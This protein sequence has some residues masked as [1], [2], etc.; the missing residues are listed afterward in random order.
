MKN[1]FNGTENFNID[2]S[3][4]EINDNCDLSFMFFMSAFNQ[5]I[6][7]WKNGISVIETY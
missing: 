6:Y 1:M 4:W 5:P 2:L 7:T 3:N